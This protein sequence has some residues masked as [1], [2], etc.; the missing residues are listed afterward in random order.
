MARYY[1]SDV[2]GDFGF[3]K[4]FETQTSDKN[5]FL[6]KAADGATVVAGMYCQYPKLKHY[7]LGRLVA[8]AGMATKEKF[9]RLARN[10]IEQRLREPSGNERDLL[11]FISGNSERNI[12]EPFS[13]DE[14]WAESRFTL[15][16]GTRPC[17]LSQQ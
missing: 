11:H 7:G 12:K 2:M 1:A 6:L 13:M 14:V 3:G 10:L 15:I 8:L 4:S 17:F 16:A 5:R 9:G